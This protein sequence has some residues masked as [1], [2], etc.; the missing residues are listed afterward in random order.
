[1][2]E[3]VTFHVRLTPKGGRD[4]VEGWET[5]SDGSRHVKARVRAVPEDGKANAALVQLLAKT[6]GVPKSAIEI[7]AGATARLKRIEARGE[8]LRARLEAL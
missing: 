4:A 8:N 3:T 2:D 1:M 7:V 6:L 5:A